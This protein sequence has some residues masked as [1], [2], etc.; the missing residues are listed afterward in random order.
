MIKLTDTNNNVI[1]V[2]IDNI[3]VIEPHKKGSLITPIKGNYYDFVVKETP[4]QIKQAID[5]IR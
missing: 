1:Y 5:G 4:E 3:I 2:N